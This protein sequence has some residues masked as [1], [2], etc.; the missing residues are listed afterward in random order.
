MDPQ[1]RG[2]FPPFF[3]TECAVAVHSRPTLERMTYCPHCAAPISTIRRLLTPARIRCPACRGLSRVSTPGRV[4]AIFALCVVP[5][6]ALLAWA[7]KR[8]YMP[9]FWS[10]GVVVFSAGLLVQAHGPLVPRPTITLVSIAKEFRETRW[11]RGFIAMLVALAALIL[12][13]LLYANA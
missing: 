4:Q 6:I 3:T 7:G 9:L 2:V 1:R 10:L 11:N 8:N 5:A 12:L 13:L